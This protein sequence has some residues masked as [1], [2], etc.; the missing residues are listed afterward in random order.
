MRRLAAVSSWFVLHVSLTV[1]IHLSDV[2]N[3]YYTVLYR[4][5][6]KCR[7]GIWEKESIIVNLVI[8][9]T[10]LA[11]VIQMASCSDSVWYSFF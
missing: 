6:A 8:V 11:L 2:T 1:N 3:K 9:V 10:Y 7:I 5:V 4:M